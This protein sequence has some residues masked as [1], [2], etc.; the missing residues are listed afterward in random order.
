M[1]KNNQIIPSAGLEPAIYG[2]EDRCIIRLCYEGNKSNTLR[3][4]KIP[5][6]AAIRENTVLNIAIL[7]LCLSSHLST[8]PLL[9]PV[10]IIFISLY[11]TGRG[12]HC[13]ICCIKSKWFS[14]GGEAFFVHNK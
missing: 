14:V 7:W 8:N 11:N 12:Q 6:R 2:L 3:K 5:V 9:L 13:I 4:T 10:S 1:K